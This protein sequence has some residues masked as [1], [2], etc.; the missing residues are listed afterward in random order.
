FR[1][2]VALADAVVAEVEFGLGVPAAPQVHPTAVVSPRAELAD[3]VRIGPYALV[4]SDV[5]IGADTWVG[6]HAVVEGRTRIGARNRIFPFASVGAVPQDLKYRGEPSVL[7]IGDANIVREY[8]SINPGTEG[9]AM[10]TRVGSGCLF[11]VSSHVAHDCR[12]GDS[13]ILAN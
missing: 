9:G 11:M 4:G 1:G 12:L 5:A 6:G 13:V 3:G 8:V 2:I 10:E 7:T